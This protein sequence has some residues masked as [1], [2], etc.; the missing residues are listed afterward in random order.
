MRDSQ[1]NDVP[2]AAVLGKYYMV[3]LHP[4]EDA[5]K[6]NLQ[7]QHIKALAAAGRHAPPL[8]AQQTRQPQPQVTFASPANQARAGGGAGVMGLTSVSHLGALH[9]ASPSSHTPQFPLPQ[10]AL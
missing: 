5:Y 3:L 4:F 1:G 7:S 10:Q 8:V 9:A 6:Q 2:A